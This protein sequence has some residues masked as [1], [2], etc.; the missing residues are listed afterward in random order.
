MPSPVG[1]RRK[2][3]NFFQTRPFSDQRRFGSSAILEAVPFWKQGARFRPWAVNRSTA[4]GGLSESIG[5]EVAEWSK[6]AD[7]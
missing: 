3:S 5:G 6:A 7:C 2:S 4:G 1:P